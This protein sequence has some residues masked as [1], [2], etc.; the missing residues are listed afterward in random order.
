MG[1]FNKGTNDPFEGSFM[2]SFTGPNVFFLSFF[3][4]GGGLGVYGAGV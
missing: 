1:S 4:G 3:L 2:G